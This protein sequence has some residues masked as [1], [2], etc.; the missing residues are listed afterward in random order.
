M[1]SD[2]DQPDDDMITAPEPETEEV[3]H[4]TNPVNNGFTPTLSGS[5]WREIHILLE[6]TYKN[7]P[8]AEKSPA[9]H[10]EVLHEMYESFPK[11]ELIIYDNQA[12][13]VNRESCGKWTDMEAYKACFNLH[14]GYG[15][16]I[17]I[18]RIRTTQRFGTIKRAKRV[19]A[20]LLETGSYLKRHHWPEDKWQ[21]TTLGFL[22]LMDPSRHQ[23]DDTREQIIRLS[24]KEKCNKKEGERFKLI[25]ERIKFNYNGITTTHAFGIQCLKEDVHAVDEMLK[26]T[27][28]ESL[29]YVKNK[30]KKAHKEAYAN[31]MRIQ[32]VYLSQA[33]TV[34][35][36]GITRRMME[37][38]RPKLIH[39]ESV[40][41]VVSTT[42]TDSIGRWDLITTDG[43][44]TKLLEI[45]NANLEEWLALCVD[46][47][48]QPTDFP[49][50]G[51]QTKT[52]RP[53]DDEDSEDSDGGVSYL[54]SS[55]GSYA[56]AI[57]S[58]DRDD[59]REEPTSRV[60]TGVTWAQVAS[61]RNPQGSTGSSQPTQSEISGLTNP[62]NQATANKKYDEMEQRLNAKISDLTTQMERLIA[63]GIADSNRMQSFLSTI[64]G[65]TTAQNQQQHPFQGN[66]SQQQ[67][68]YDYGGR[69]AAPWQDRVRPYDRPYGPHFGAP[70]WQPPG[71][72]LRA[73]N[74]R[75]Y[76]SEQELQQHHSQ[77]RSKTPP[78]RGGE[79]Q[80]AARGGG[81][82]S[83]RAPNSNAKRKTTG[84]EPAAITP[85]NRI[86][87]EGS[88]D[89]EEDNHSRHSDKKKDQRVTPQRRI[90]QEMILRAS[91]PP[92]ASMQHNPYDRPA[93]VPTPM[94]PPAR[95]YAPPPTGWQRQPDDAYGAYRQSEDIA[96]P[97]H[98]Q[99]SRHL[100]E[101]QQTYGYQECFDLADHEME[102]AE[103]SRPAE[104]AR[105]DH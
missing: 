71:T 68:Q 20:K 78:R 47:S 42:K 16:Q 65:N 49:E 14:D 3:F 17:V 9:K 12:R 5:E 95:R 36:V 26:D 99:Q 92:A 6:I 10:L 56:N 8:E 80:M 50:P 74:A 58:Y 81:R 96:Y 2:A 86:N 51:L 44:H 103:E 27:Y 33:N 55:A 94:Q 34:V 84:E 22:C 18:F 89:D 77:Q 45:L 41:Y 1:A 93:M 82:H 52:N 105:H 66:P 40:D 21:V 15:R 64:Q 88:D 72:A 38:L 91:T 24:K 67:N 29:T 32:N 35:L 37:Q 23:E 13:K 76:P 28:R 57:A 87:N 7:K 61:R 31:G 39:I 59:F 43:K 85:S 63:N 46:T 98:H 30:L 100:Y 79:R 19:W 73:Q 48:E 75:N 69:P 83:G 97:P 101:P 70:P 25:P 53:D 102:S 4:D 62:A 90:T 60:F 11:N 54:S 104:D